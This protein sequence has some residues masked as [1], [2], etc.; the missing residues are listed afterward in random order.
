MSTT[1]T[2][3]P[4]DPTSPRTPARTDAAPARLRVGPV[5]WPRAAWSEWLKFATLRSTWAVLGAAVLGMV[6]LG[7]VIAYNTRNPAGLDP[8]DT[9]PSATLQ[10]YYLGQLLIASLGVLVVTGEYSTGMIRS[11]FAAV[12]RRLPVLT[13]KL[14]V[15]AVIVAVA[16]TAASLAAFTLAQAVMSRYRPGYSL[17]DPGVLRVVIG[18]GIY[19]TLIGL[20]GSAIGWI[21]RSTPGA[22]VTVVGLLLVVPVLFGNLLGSWGRTVAAYLPTGAGASFSTTH[23]NPNGLSPWTGFGVLLA[24]VVVGFVVAAVELRRRDA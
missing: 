19:L 22:L 12:P 10:G 24:W 9:V 1:L 7:A 20:I 6:V 13:A 14:A 16:M 15:F 17:S 18:T 21:V 4:R 23:G 5:T 8:E 3:R 11:T 2:D